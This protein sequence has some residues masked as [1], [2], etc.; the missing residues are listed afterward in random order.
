MDTG[1][2]VSRRSRGI[3]R[4]NSRSLDSG[5]ASAIGRQQTSVRAVG[6]ARTPPPTGGDERGCEPGQSEMRSCDG[7]D[8]TTSTVRIGCLNRTFGTNAVFRSVRDPN[9]RVVLLYNRRRSESRIMSPASAYAVLL[10]SS[11]LLPRVHRRPR[12]LSTP[13]ASRSMEFRNGA[14]ASNFV[15]KVGHSPDLLSGAFCR[16]LLSLKAEGWHPQC[17]RLQAANQRDAVPTKTSNFIGLK[18]N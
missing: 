6:R 15:R 5:C 18:A 4:G 1:K 16:D 7:E 13:A 17:Q 11:V 2:G 10:F 3:L 9:W 8:A 12:E 14:C